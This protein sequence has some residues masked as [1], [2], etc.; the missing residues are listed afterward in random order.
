MEVWLS[1]IDYAVNKKVSL[2][3]LRRRIKAQ[4]LESRME[5][6]KYLIKVEFEKDSAD[7]A[8][9]LSLAESAETVQNL[10]TELKKAY[11]LVLTEKEELI[12][13]LK[14]EIEI[15]KHINQFLEQQILK[16][17]QK[18]DQGRGDFIE[19]DLF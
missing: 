9:K 3:T 18:E 10:I 8:E 7:A 19:P 5:N 11:G 6:G 12:Q 17:D 1:V 15:L 16:E 13:Q 4:A 14:S 2:S